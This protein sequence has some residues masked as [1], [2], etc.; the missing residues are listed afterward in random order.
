MEIRLLKEDY[1]SKIRP[2]E[3]TD[4]SLYHAF[5]CDKLRS[6]D[7]LSEEK[8]HITDGSDFPIYFAMKDQE[9]KT[10]AFLELVHLIDRSFLSLD[11][12]IY[13]DERF[14]HSYLCLYKR[15]YL[16]RTYP[17]ILEDEKA[18]YN[19][20][21]KKF[22][23]ENYIY[24][25]ILM[26]QYVHDYVE[27]SRREY[28]YH[29]ILHNMDMYNYIIKYEIFRN[30]PFLIHIMEIIDETNT[31][32]ILKG[33]IRNRKDLGQ[34]ERYGRRVIFEFNKSYPMLLSPMMDKD[35]LKT[36]FLQFLGY[37]YDGQMHLFA[38]EDLPEDDW[39]VDSEEA[40][41]VW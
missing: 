29:L 19:I 39:D 35:E 8:V 37:Y 6:E 25:A 14:W 28:Y 21:L 4:I 23:W 38:E 30:G 26:A 3:V 20:V 41:T 16:I 1:K 33:R 7:F 13:M 5:V 2:E 22:D 11:R 17:Q 31:S 9:T 12:D 34:D 27:K 24:K 18:F 15:D 40:A 32:A 10:A 36:Y